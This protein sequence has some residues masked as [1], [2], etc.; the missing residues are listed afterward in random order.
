MLSKPIIN[1]VMGKNSTTVS[2]DVDTIGV[3]PDFTG[4]K[5][6]MIQSFFFIIKTPGKAKNKYPNKN[7][8]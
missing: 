1:A 3:V 4:V 2:I 6:L 7:R 8:E 5:T